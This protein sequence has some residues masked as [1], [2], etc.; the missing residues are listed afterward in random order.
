MIT[1]L[2]SVTSNVFSVGST[3]PKVGGNELGRDAFL[4]LLVTQ[5][6]YQNPLRPM[7]DRA[8][9]AELAQFSMLERIQELRKV[10]T[11]AQQLQGIGLLGRYVELLDGSKGLVKAVTMDADGPLLTVEHVGAVR[12]ADIARVH[13]GGPSSESDTTDTVEHEPAGDE[14]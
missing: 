5:L 6:R 3:T 1:G 14:E 13:L 8:F 7:D 9:L 2:P 11:A 12:L 4:Q 10:V